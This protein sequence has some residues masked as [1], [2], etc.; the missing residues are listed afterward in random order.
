MITLSMF[1]HLQ[2]FITYVHTPKKINLIILT[3]ECKSMRICDTHKCLHHN[4]YT[5]TYIPKLTYLINSIQIKYYDSALIQRIYDSL[6]I[7]MMISYNN[8][9]RIKNP[10][11]NRSD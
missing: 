11:I 4:N 7:F 10:R 8:D 6:M 5:N 9:H 1:S 3:Y 2:R